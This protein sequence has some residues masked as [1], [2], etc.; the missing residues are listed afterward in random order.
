M[1]VVAVIGGIASATA[2][3]ATFSLAAGFT[4][5]NIAA[6]LSIVGG[7][8][9]ALGGIT[10]NKKLMK[11]GM[12]AGL[13]GAALGGL[14]SL[15]AAGDA[16][17]AGGSAAAGSA[18]GAGGAQ[19]FGI[20]SPTSLTPTAIQPGMG[21]LDTAAQSGAA[22]VGPATVAASGLNAANPADFAAGA[23][24][25][26]SSVGVSG[27]PTAANVA[28][29]GNAGALQAN[30]ALRNQVTMGGVGEGASDILGK[31]TGMLGG[32]GRF[33]GDN[34]ELSKVGVSALAGMSKHKAEQAQL[35]YQQKLKEA[36]RARLNAS[37]TRQRQSY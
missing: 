22:G 26:P 16:A 30:T 29:V 6:G 33:L 27:A 35:E 34:P 18:A 15:S 13:G 5:A 10:G 8:A 21:M 25:A 9:S 20:P 23:G 31:A 12:I 2:G 4:A 37:I 19:T 24:A 7:V 1:P 14:S 3:A 36:D 17:G 28:D 11:F 32:F